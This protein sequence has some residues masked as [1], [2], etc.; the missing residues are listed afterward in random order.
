MFKKHWMDEAVDQNKHF[1]KSL[2]AHEQD[3]LL[4]NNN[5]I[6]FTL[7]SQIIQK[8]QHTN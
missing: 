7:L 6:V 4:F 1:F 3:T 8:E 5:L 2:S